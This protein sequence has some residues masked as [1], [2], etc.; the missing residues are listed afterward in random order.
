MLTVSFPKM[1]LC[2]SV[3]LKVVSHAAELSKLWARAGGREG[4][5]PGMSITRDSRLLLRC[6]ESPLKSQQ[7]LTGILMLLFP[8]V[9]T[10]KI[11]LSNFIVCKMGR[12]IIYGNSASFSRFPSQPG[13]KGKRKDSPHNECL[14]FIVL[15]ISKWIPRSC[16][17]QETENFRL[18]FP[19]YWPSF[20]ALRKMLMNQHVHILQGPGMGLHHVGWGPGW[21]QGLCLFPQLRTMFVSTGAFRGVCK[22]IDHFPEDADYEQDTAEYLL[23]KFPT[24]W[25]SLCRGKGALWSSSCPRVW[26]CSYPLLEM[27][28]CKGPFRGPLLLDRDFQVVLISKSLI[29]MNRNRKGKM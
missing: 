8:C 29:S 13:K 19:L 7:I 26:G 6:L 16:Q 11:P 22:K 1:Q 15:C 5:V 18:F 23:R 2:S 21:A 27:N 25:V 3:P 28:T 20:C 12:W 17:I 4:P 10:S 9:S 14:G 24:S